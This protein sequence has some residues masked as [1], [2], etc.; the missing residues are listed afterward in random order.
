M[1]D[2]PKLKNS[3][4]SLLV[5][6]APIQPKEAPIIK[7]PQ[8][9]F[10]ACIDDICISNYRTISLRSAESIITVKVSSPISMRLEYLFRKCYCRNFFSTKTN[11]IL[12]N[13]ILQLLIL[14]VLVKI[15]LNGK[16][17]L[18]TQE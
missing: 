3:T 2:D 7:E 15:N 11:I 10:R 12:S 13:Y 8:Y 16:S 14:V 4:I 9:R 18:A 6:Q 5:S 1:T 17:L